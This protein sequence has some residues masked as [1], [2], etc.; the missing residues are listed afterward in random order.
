MSQ[1]LTRMTDANVDR[2]LQLAVGQ[3]RSG[4]LAEA[5][6]AYR[7]ILSRHPDHAEAL[8]L[9]GALAVQAG[10]V[11]AGME[12]MRRAIRLK[13]DYAEAHNNLGIV[14][15]NAGQTDEAMASYHR[16]IRLEPDYAEAHYNLGV[17][18][19][20]GGQLDE[21]IACYRQAIRLKP[22]YAEAHY[23]LGVAFK[24]K[25]QFDEAIT[26]CRQAIRFKPDLAEAHNNLGF[27]LQITGRLDE[28]IASYR[29]ALRLKPDYA[30]AH[31]NL[32][33]AFNYHPG[34]DAGMIFEE[35]RRWN[36]QHT[37]PLK[38]FIRPHTNDRNPDRRLRIG[39]VSPDFREHPVGRFLLPV[40]EHHD[41]Q[42]FEIFCYSS[43]TR[44]DAITARFRSVADHWQEIRNSSDDHAA[45]Q[46]RADG[47][48]VLVDLSG[49]TAGNRL[50]VF[51]RK[52]AP[53]QVSYLGYPGTTGLSTIDYR[54]TDGL[55][56][57]PGLTDGFHTE[58]LFRLPQSNWCYAEPDD[59]P[60][61][62][63]PPAIGRGHVTFG[64]F[65]SFA[66]ATEAMLQIWGRILH[67]V[68]GSRLILK[69]FA[70]GSASVRDRIRRN[71]AAQGIGADRL[72]LSGP[73]PDRLSHLASY[74][75]M[76]IALN[77]FPYHGTTTTCEALWMGVPVVTLV[78]QSHVSRVGLS[79]LSN[80]GLPEL[81]AAT[82]DQYVKL[83]VNLAK[84]Q[85]RLK[86][87]RDS[88][89]E[90]MRSSPLMDAP[91]FARDVEAAYR[92]MWR[93]WCA[94]GK[95]S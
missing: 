84:D 29:Q 46:I 35:L 47:I 79:L 82:P 8:Q 69:T 81:A 28:A 83:A 95:N 41:H 37:E 18:L 43:V 14:L 31:D 4:H 64:S 32:I 78:G 88:L 21:A 92:Q 74:A 63:P 68:P 66:K 9:L 7:Q 19:M 30:E 87:L 22:D 45:D 65:N 51:A 80:V 1:G 76:D 36:Q 39:Y 71:F 70:F 89:R 75:E 12:L 85:D 72:D 52:P 2:A 25:E 54:L 61:V 94:A 48:D 73:Q 40:L 53:V 13:P 34:Y 27:L 56:D 15:Q 67:E 59:S 24:N 11:E 58:S 10:R 6:T 93:S 3:H 91:R 20:A 42:Q 23:N 60:P 57:P 44:P 90:R 17:A 16:A 86:A 5:E 55:A 77:T 62:Q 38:K 49:H 26:S 50:L 33:F